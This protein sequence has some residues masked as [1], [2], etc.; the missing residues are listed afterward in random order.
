MSLMRIF[1]LVWGVWLLAGGTGLHA[2]DALKYSYLPKKV[3]KNQVF[4][5][6]IID[7]RQDKEPLHYRFDLSRGGIRLILVKPL[8][9]RNGSDNFYTFYYKAVGNE[10]V[11]PRIAAE[12]KH[13]RTVLNKHVIPVVE[14]D[15]P[16]TFC[17]VLAADMHIRNH[18]VS[19]YDEKNYL[20]TLSVEAYEANLEDMYLTGVEEYGVEALKRH[21]AKVGGE[22][23]VVVPVT[24]KVLNFSYYNTIKEQYVPFSVSVSLQDSTVVTQSDLNPKEDSFEKLKRYTFIVL[25]GFFFLMFFLYRD[26]FYLILGTVSLI[27][28]LTFYI[29]KEKV[30]IKQGA[31]LYILPTENSTVSTKVAERMKTVLLGERLNYKKIEYKN[32][33]IGWVKDED[34]CKN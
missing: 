18:Q 29:P 13:F 2:E 11:I 21:G 26:I 12:S 10:V 6:T 3:Y 34:L 14:L 23:Y 9:I 33:M 28:L 8:V 1:L 32:G 25:V 16:K 4:P 20:V 31:P 5:V 22:F 24:T 30:C 17:G 15:P 19:H 7:T 27:T